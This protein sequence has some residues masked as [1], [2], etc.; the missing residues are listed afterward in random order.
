[1]RFCKSKQKSIWHSTQNSMLELRCQSAMVCLDWITY[2]KFQCLLF[3]SNG[4]FHTFF[5][6]SPSELIWCFCFV[7]TAAFQNRNKR[8]AKRRN[9]NLWI[10][11]ICTNVLFDGHLLRRLCQ[12]KNCLGIQFSVCKRKRR[13]R[14]HGY[15]NNTWDQSSWIWCFCGLF[16]HLIQQKANSQWINFSHS[17]FIILFS[18]RLAFLFFRL[19]ITSKCKRTTDESWKSYWIFA[20]DQLKSIV[21]F[22]TIAGTQ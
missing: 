13:R 8:H 3:I 20:S 15:K 5:F 14:R 19:V 11:N 18:L 7:S 17:S 10:R 9:K 4:F 12:I 6:L 2:P 1:M 22:N 21:V 16:W